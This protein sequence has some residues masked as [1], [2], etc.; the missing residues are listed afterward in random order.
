MPLSLAATSVSLAVVVLGA[1]VAAVKEGDRGDGW[2]VKSY[3][4][5][6]MP[7][8]T[9]EKILYCEYNGTF[10]FRPNPEYSCK[11]AK[12]KARYLTS[13]SNKCSNKGVVLRAYTESRRQKY[14]LQAVKKKGDPVPY[15][16][17]VEC[18]GQSCSAVYLAC[19]DK[20]Q[21]V[22]DDYESIG[23]VEWPTID[24]S[25]S[26]NKKWLWSIFQGEFDDELDCLVVNLS[27]ENYKYVLPIKAN[28][29]C[30]AIQYDY[31]PNF[32]GNWILEPANEQRG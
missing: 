9:G 18:K 4:D 14:R 12:G 6:D 8:G 19:P 28:D 13:D 11:N 21:E 26:S 25:L 1:V 31:S 7:N 16:S 23:P 10:R 32:W 15:Y 17:I 29:D 27:T 20:K 30:D 3:I 24:L 22:D 5:D 2:V